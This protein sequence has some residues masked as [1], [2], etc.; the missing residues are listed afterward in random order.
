MQM[1]PVDQNKRWLKISLS[2]PE[3]MVE[4]VSDLVGILSGAGVEITPARQ[5]IATVSGFFSVGPDEPAEP[6]K[7]KVQTELESLFS[8]YGADLGELVCKEFADAD[9]ATKWQQYFTPFAIVPG[10]VIKPSWEQY[11]V[12]DNEQVI[13]MDPG[14]AFGTGQH[15]STRLALA[16][17]RRC[18]SRQPP[19]RVLD[20]GTGTGILA[21]ASALFGA[22]H[23]LAIDNDPQAVEIAAHNVTH[24]HLQDRIHTSTTPIAKIEDSFDLICANI[25]HDVLVA[26]IPDFR[27]LLPPGGVLILAG[28]LQGE[29]ERNLQNLLSATGLHLE[30]SNRDGEWVGL[31]FKR[32]RP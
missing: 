8:L 15:E 18:C 27:R 22:E 21:M 23:I 3:Q 6:L 2:C 32:H 12:R 7:E 24:N 28:V 11:T 26:M 16:L 19:S 14:M 25:V 9:W 10:L 4:S 30:D 20:V 31:F 5:K 13:E 29:Q 17:I 1:E